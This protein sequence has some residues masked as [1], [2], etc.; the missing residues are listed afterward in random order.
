MTL[1]ETI[2]KFRLGGRGGKQTFV[3][4]ERVLIQNQAFRLV[5]ASHQRIGGLSVTDGE[6]EFPVGV[7]R[8]ISNERLANRQSLPV[9]IN[10]R[11]NP[12]EIAFINVRLH[13]S[14]F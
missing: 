11:V 9:V 7:L 8:F 14:Y 10:S 2:T 4:F 6:R 3:N 12:A 13:I 1:R 5:A